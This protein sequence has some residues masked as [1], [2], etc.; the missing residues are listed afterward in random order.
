[1]L[2]QKV[3][4]L[5]SLINTHSIN[6]ILTM[7]S[8]NL[9]I[10]PLTKINCHNIGNLRLSLSPIIHGLHHASSPPNVGGVPKGRGGPPFS[11]QNSFPELDHHTTP[12]K[13]IFT[14]IVYTPLR[15]NLPYLKQIRKKLRN[16][17]TPAEARLWTLIKNNQLEGRKFRRQFS[18][19]NYVLDFY[20]PEEKLAIEM[21]GVYHF[22]PYQIAK[23]KQRD[24]YLNSVGIRVLRF[25]N[26]RLWNDADGLINE[27]KNYLNRVR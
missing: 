16:N 9:L 10:H 21:D 24:A 7:F 13:A 27:I 6:A 11:K 23:D 15:K 22:T 26:K 12:K 20:C 8:P 17:M 14:Y 18:V 5:Q 3:Y 19:A 4:L 2:F 25:E 1:M